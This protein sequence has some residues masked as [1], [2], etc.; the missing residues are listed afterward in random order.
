MSEALRKALAARQ[1]VIDLRERRYRYEAQL[2]RERAA[3]PLQSAFTRKDRNGTTQ[4]SR[5]IR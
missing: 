3:R 4:Q 1:K 5:D 2:R